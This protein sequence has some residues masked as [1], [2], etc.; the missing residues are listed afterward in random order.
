MLET[1]ETTDNTLIHQ[2]RRVLKDGIDYL[3]SALTLLQARAAEM[4]LSSLVFAALLMFAAILAMA[5]LVLMIVAL[6]F[7]LTHVTGNV[8]WS[9]LIIGGLL[10]VIAA[11]SAWRALRWL[12]QLKS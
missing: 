3:G 4:A 9:L 11:A 8:G 12:N 5:A 6:G 1:E 7:W 2:L 10:A